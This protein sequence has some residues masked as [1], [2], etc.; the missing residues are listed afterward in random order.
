MKKTSVTLESLQSHMGSMQQNMEKSFET[1]AK[2]L[3]DIQTD[4]IRVQA[5]LENI[6]GELVDIQGN[7]SYLVAEAVT[8][9]DVR[10][11]VREEMGPI[12]APLYA[13][14]DQIVYKHQTFEGEV[15]AHEHRITSLERAVGLPM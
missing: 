8:R 11:I 7:M 3:A 9:T 6:Q 15:L 14:M 10:E 4:T 5:T 12:M 1:I 13:T 2:T